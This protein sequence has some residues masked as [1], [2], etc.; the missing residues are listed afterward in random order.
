[1]DE[2]NKDFENNNE[3]DVSVI[4][5]RK[6]WLFFGLP[7]TFTK[8]ILDGK[9][10]GLHK[11][12][13]NTTEDEILLYRIMDLTV[14]RSLFQKMAGLGTIFVVSSDQTNPKLELKNIKHTSDFKHAL[15]DRIESERMRMRFRAGEY[16]EIDS[17]V[18]DV[19][20]DIHGNA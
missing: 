15:D 6:R 18:N 8:Y 4:K 9:R 5:E 17:D 2:K 3:K 11:G 14:K 13:F 1:M 10:L 12:F 20:E 16:A 7:F 19:H